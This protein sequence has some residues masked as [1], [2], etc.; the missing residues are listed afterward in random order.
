MLGIWWVSAV[1]SSVLS[2]L[3]T[4]DDSSWEET[5]PSHWIRVE[6]LSCGRG[7]LGRGRGEKKAAGYVRFLHRE[8]LGWGNEC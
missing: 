8:G 2:L 6:F 7:L 4:T 5:V 1:V 3:W